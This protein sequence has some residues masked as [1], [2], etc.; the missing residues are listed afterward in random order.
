MKEG[1]KQGRGK[2]RKKGTGPTDEWDP[3]HSEGEA[4]C[5]QR[6]HAGQAERAALVGWRAERAAVPSSGPRRSRPARDGPR[7]GGRE[8][9]CWAASRPSR[10]GEGRRGRAKTRAGLKIK[11]VFQNP[12]SNFKFFSKSISFL[13][14]KQILI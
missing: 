5:G 4:A 1:K 11:R 10:E 12:F 14:S 7:T 9:G 13:N 3:G 8:E 6:R 2:E